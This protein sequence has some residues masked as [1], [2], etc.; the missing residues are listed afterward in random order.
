MTQMGTRHLMNNNGTVLTVQYID[1]ELVM[2]FSTYT[3]RH[4]CTHERAHAYT[5]T[6]SRQR[7]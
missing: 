3:C 1:V 5:H 6:P 4:M 7:F 2:N